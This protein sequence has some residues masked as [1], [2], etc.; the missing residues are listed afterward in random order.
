MKMAVQTRAGRGSTHAIKN[1]ESSV[2]LTA[3]QEKK[4]EYWHATVGGLC[5]T[6]A[7]KLRRFSVATPS[8]GFN[9]VFTKVL[10][11]ICSNKVLI[12]FI[13]V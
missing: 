9:M 12:S 5:C 7:V 8:W 6:C 2:C 1:P 13:N 10:I 4:L 11:R 3:R